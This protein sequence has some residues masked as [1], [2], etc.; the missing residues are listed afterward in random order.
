MLRDLHLERY[1]DVLL[2]GLRTSR[3]E[4]FKKGDVILIQYDRA[5]VRLAEML[6]DRIVAAGMNVV[7]RQGLTAAMEHSFFGKAKGRQLTFIAPGEKEFIGSLH[8][9]IYLHA[10]ES[11]THLSKIDPSRISEFY[12]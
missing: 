7:Q 10:P 6:Y 8:G 5:A 11:L 12:A 4:R 3:R 1:A 9:R 2:W